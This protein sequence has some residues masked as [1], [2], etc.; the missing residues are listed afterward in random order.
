MTAL[1][2]DDSATIRQMATLA[3]AE[4]GFDVVHGADGQEGVRRLDGRALD[5][6][7]TDL[8]MPAL[9]GIGLCRAARTR[10]AYRSTPILVLASDNSASRRLEGRLAGATGW[11]V[12]P[13]DPRLLQDA[14]RRVVPLSGG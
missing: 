8:V 4:L 2:V 7:V 12:K 5:L 3:L 6:I 11:I 9:D 14:V 10:A 13:F 1:V